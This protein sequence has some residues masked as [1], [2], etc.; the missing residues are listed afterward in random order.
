MKKQEFHLSL[1]FIL[2]IFPGFQM[3][4]MEECLSDAFIARADLL[5]ELKFPTKGLNRGI[6]LF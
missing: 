3:S 2:L 4:L 6:F 5:Q 1:R